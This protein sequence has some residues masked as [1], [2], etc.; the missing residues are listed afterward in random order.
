[1][2]LSALELSIQ[3]K[4]TKR[5]INSDPTTIILVPKQ[6]AIVNGTKSFIPTSPRQPQTF[7]IIWTGENG[8]VR[9]PSESGPGAHRYDFVLLGEHD[10]E[11]SI[12]DFWQVGSQKFV[13]EEIFPENGY[14]VKA[15]GVSHGPSPT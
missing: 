5:F 13:I 6:E 12:G 4:T 3:R 9:Q 1:M 7:K 2:T 11:V 15:G 10:A 8:I 14:E